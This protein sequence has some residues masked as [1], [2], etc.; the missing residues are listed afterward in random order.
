MQRCLLIH[1]SLLCNAKNV[2]PTKKCSLG[3]K[4]D[5]WHAV[6]EPP[7]GNLNRTPRCINLDV[8][9]RCCTVHKTCQH[10]L[11]FERSARSQRENSR[12]VFSIYQERQNI[13]TLD[14]AAEV[15]EFTN[16]F[17]LNARPSFPLGSVLCLM[18]VWL[19]VSEI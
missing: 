16:A 15:M 14:P 10:N 1:H 19:S 6:N 5:A 13:Q 18:L 2:W 8:F 12:D 4:S 3:W 7:V 9:N 11:S 17:W